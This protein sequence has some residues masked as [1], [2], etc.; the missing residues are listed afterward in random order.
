MAAGWAELVLLNP[1]SLRLSAEPV[2][3]THNALGL[4]ALRLLLATLACTPLRRLTGYGPVL[5]LRR[6]LG[7]WCFAYAVAH[8]G[9]Y[10]AMELDFSLSAL[11]Q[12][13][14]KRRFILFG[15]LAFLALAP[16]ALTSTRAAIKALGGKRWQRLHRLVYLAGL[17][18]CIHFILRVKGFQ[19]EPWVYA[20]LFAMLMLLRIRPSRQRASP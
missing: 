16:L 15:L 9:F 1:A 2:A 8:L 12:E 5:S 7:L 19:P 3:H 4:A 11:W 14:L 18:A 6:M 20:T 17:A 13:A 10:L